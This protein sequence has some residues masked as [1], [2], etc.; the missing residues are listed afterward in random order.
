MITALVSLSCNS[1]VSGQTYFKCFIPKANPTFHGQ[2]FSSRPPISLVPVAYWV[3]AAPPTITI[4]QPFWAERQGS[5]RTD[6]DVQIQPYTRLTLAIGDL[7]CLA[8]I[9]L[10]S[11]VVGF[12]PVSAA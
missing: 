5:I 9:G 4:T 6:S 7:L 1:S 3:S 12:S 2:S 11:P 10:D 8:L